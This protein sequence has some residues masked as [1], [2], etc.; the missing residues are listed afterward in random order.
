MKVGIVGAGIM[1]Q[2]LA[3]ELN[4]AGHEISLFDHGWGKSRSN[5][6]MSA[7]GL[8]A[9]VTELDKCGHV[10]YQ[11]GSD[12]LYYWPQI[13]KHLDETIFHKFSGSLMVAHPGERADLLRA[14]EMIDYKFNADGVRRHPDIT[15]DNN[16]DASEKKYVRLNQRELAGLEPEL[17]K[18]NEAYFFPMEGQID[19][20]A[21]MLAINQYLRTQGVS[22]FDMHVEEIS[23]SGIKAGDQVY[24]FDMIFDCR[25]LAAKEE[26]DNLHAVRGELIWLHAAD[27]NIN[28]PVRFMHPRYNL[29]IA[30][31][32]GN[33][34]LIG[35]SEIYAEDYSEISVR[36]A[37]EL[38]TA[39]YYVHPGFAEARIIKT[40]THCRPVLADHLPKIKRRDNLIAVNGLYRHGFLIAPTLAVEISRWLD[41]GW[42]ALRYP[43]LWEFI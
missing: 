27:V 31:R 20:Q 34:Y 32:P 25:G 3:L 22:L 15:Q 26:F 12:A 8:L 5:C 9:P 23:I 6:S 42:T 33:V 14:V 4:N 1:G 21:V 39:A 38:L 13:L 40:I 35:A 16:I 10:I 24:M 37:L 7:A 41:L 2:L 17:G 11:L 18:F 19:N 29:Y 30:P 28:R 36:T 43:Q